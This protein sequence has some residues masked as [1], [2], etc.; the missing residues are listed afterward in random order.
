MFFYR[1]KQFFWAINSKL[2]DED[3]VFINKNLTKK[4]LNLFYKLSR[5]EQKHCINVSYD[6]MEVCKKENLNTKI[7]VKASLL[8]DI[9]KIY[10]KITIMDKSII[11][12]ADILSKGYIKKLNNFKKIQVYYNHGEIG[13]K[14]LNRYNYDDK[15]LYLIKNHHNYEI[16][17]DRELNIL[18]ICDDRN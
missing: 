9:G 18:K 7:L 4:E 1:I 5:H 14:M 11:V 12:I 2:N 8:H 16:K 13:Y 17:D 15:I 6:V 3:I 10:K